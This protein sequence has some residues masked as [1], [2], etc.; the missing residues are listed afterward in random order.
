MAPKGIKEWE[1]HLD[2]AIELAE[3][4]DRAASLSWNVD[5]S[6]DVRY[7]LEQAA[8][9]MDLVAGRIALATG[10]MRRQEKGQWLNTLS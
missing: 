6:D 9:K 5:G 2:R 1:E 4:I 3:T 7:I 8:E 10:R